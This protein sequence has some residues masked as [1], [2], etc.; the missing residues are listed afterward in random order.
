MHAVLTFTFFKGTMIVR[1]TLKKMNSIVKKIKTFSERKGNFQ[2]GKE[3]THSNYL[4]MLERCRDKEPGNL[5]FFSER[6]I[7]SASREEKIDLTQLSNS[8]PQ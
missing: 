1:N 3:K 2:H 8:F 7:S 6:L 4:P 5:F